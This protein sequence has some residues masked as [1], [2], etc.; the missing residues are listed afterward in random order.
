MKNENEK[1]AEYSWD[2]LIGLLLLAAIPFF[3]TLGTVA[4]N[5]IKK[6]AERGWKI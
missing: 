1:K 6:L 5:E 4:A 3:T 2:I